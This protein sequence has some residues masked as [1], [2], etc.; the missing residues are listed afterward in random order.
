[1]LSPLFNVKRLTSATAVLRGA[2][3]SM[4][5]LALGLA[6]AGNSQ[7]AQTE[8]ARIALPAPTQAQFDL[9]ATIPVPRG[10][11]VNENGSMPLRVLNADGSPAPTQIE[12]VSGYANPSDGADVVELI[13]R[14]NRPAGSEIGN[15]IVYSVVQS[16]HNPGSFQLPSPV[17]QLLDSPE[18]IQLIG[19]DV[20]GNSYSADLLRDV[21]SGQSRGF[22]SGELMQQRGGHEI[23]TPDPGPYPQGAPMPHMMGAKTYVT[24]VKGRNLVIIDLVIHNGLDGKRLE[25][26]ADDVL[27]KLYFKDL[28]IEVPAGWTIHTAFGSPFLSDQVTANGRSSRDL[29]GAFANGDMHYMPRQSQFVRRLVISLG[30]TF[31]Y[32]KDMLD[33]RFLGFS[34][35]GRSLSSGDELWS[36]WNPLTARYF[37]QRQ[38]LPTLQN[39]DLGTI[40]TNL[41]IEMARVDM[42]MSTGDAGIYPFLSPALGWAHPWGVAYGGM[43]GGDEINL[44]DG[45][46]TVTTA[47]NRGYKLM[48]AVSKSYLDRMPFALYNIDGEPTTKEDIVVTEGFGA[49]YLPGTFFMRPSTNYIDWYGFDQVSLDHPRAVREQNAGPDYEG[50]LDGWQMIDTQHLIRFTRTWKVMAWLGNDAVSKEMLEATFERF[51]MSYQD[52]PNGAYGYAQGTGM[53]RDLDHVRLYPNQGVAIGRSEAWGLDAAMAAYALTDTTRRETIAEWTNQVVDLIADGQSDCTGNIMAQY[54]Y[55][56][57]YVRYNVRLSRETGFLDQAL[58]SVSKT[59]YDSVNAAD[60]QR[61]EEILLRSVS[62]S[63]EPP[64]WSESLQAPWVICPSGSYDLDLFPDLCRDIP[65]GSQSPDVDVTMYWSSLAYAYELSQDPV[66]LHKA[67]QMTASGDLLADFLGGQAGIDIESRSAFMALLETLYPN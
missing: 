58:R 41:R 47:S 6:L 14:V 63:I 36:W 12:W 17:E 49:P 50:E 21:R 11:F 44:V 25:S 56:P 5:A 16:N 34:R 9:R 38:L 29:V 42:Q 55:K 40:A 1:M 54:V 28:K 51:R 23:M 66:F 13:A 65:D 48:Q 22:R 18:A 35:R 67:A 57:Q 10:T 33:E 7:A 15:E 39:Q 31:Q 53:L 64:F 62:A 37:P 45:V 59:M 61:V 8:V 24:T 46:R 19:R 27:N 60:Q 4:A 26:S 20:F 32:G 2:V 30:D 43:T 3:S 52:L